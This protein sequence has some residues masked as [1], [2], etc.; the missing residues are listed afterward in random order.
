VNGPNGGS[1]STSGGVTKDANGNVVGGRSTTATGQ[2]G[3]SYDGSTTVSNGTVT[4]TGTCTN[5]AGEVISCRG[6]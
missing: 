6:N 4:H 2:N 1:A 3:N 5:A